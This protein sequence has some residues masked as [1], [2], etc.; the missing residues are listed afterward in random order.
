MREFRVIWKREEGFPDEE[1][2]EMHP[3]ATWEASCMSPRVNLQV[4]DPT[5]P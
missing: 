4:A 3:R 1:A 5:L 2:F